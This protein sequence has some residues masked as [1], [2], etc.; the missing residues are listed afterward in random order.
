MSLAKR[1]SLGVERMLEQVKG[2]PLL[3][4]DFK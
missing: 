3:P 1:M 2:A 4:L